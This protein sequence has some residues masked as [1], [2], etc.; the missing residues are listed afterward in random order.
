M[1]AASALLGNPGDGVQ[2]TAVYIHV[3]VNGGYGPLSYV[4]LAHRSVT[5]HP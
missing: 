2:I 4:S 3:R 1:H 5:W